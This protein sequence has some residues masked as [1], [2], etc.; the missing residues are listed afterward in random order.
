M[1]SKRAREA[2]CRPPVP[3]PPPPLHFSFPPFPPSKTIANCGNF[4]QRLKLKRRTDDDDDED[5]ERASEQASRGR[6]A[7]SHTPSAITVIN[8]VCS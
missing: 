7:Q 2:C 1:A 3:P 6:A 5:S 4:F 8:E